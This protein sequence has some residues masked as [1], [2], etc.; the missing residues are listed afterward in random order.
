MHKYGIINMVMKMATVKRR[1]ELSDD[2]WERIKD[3]LP[4]DKLEKQGRPP[5][6]IGMWES[7]KREPN[8]KKL[9][10]IA[11][12]FNVSTDYLLGREGSTNHNNKQGFDHEEIEMIKKYRQL[13]KRLKQAVNAILDSQQDNQIQDT[14]VKSA[15]DEACAIEVIDD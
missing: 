14:A 2:E 1:Y 8:F 15:S 7:G 4:S 6:P 11:N 10:E 9:V 5:K 12:Y 13:D 3:M